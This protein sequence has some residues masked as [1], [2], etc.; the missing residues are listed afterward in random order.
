MKDAITAVVSRYDLTGK[1]LDKIA[2]EELNSYFSSAL[3]RIRIVEVINC[4]AAKIIK[5]ATSRLYEEQ[6]E[7]LRPGGNS[8]TTRRYSVCL[9]DVEYYLRYASYAVAAGS[10]DILN[11]RVLNG[12]KDTYNSLNVPIAQTARSI[13]ILQEITEKELSLVNIDAKNLVDRPFQH[14]IHALSEE[15]L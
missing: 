9:R 7:L 2:I 4:Q 14:M 6:P 11:E 1:Y 15:N 3:S 13:K 5:E 10:N 12:L 8:Y